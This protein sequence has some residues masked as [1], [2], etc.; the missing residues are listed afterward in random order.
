MCTARARASSTGHSIVVRG[1]AGPLLRAA[2]PLEQAEQQQ[3]QRVDGTM[4]E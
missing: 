2:V 3:Q 4:Y 1:A